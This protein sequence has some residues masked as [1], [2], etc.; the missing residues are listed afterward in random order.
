[1]KKT[2]LPSIIFILVILSGYK[3]YVIFKQKN[4][5]TKLR[6]TNIQSE[7]E[8]FDD[9]DVQQNTSTELEEIK[10]G[11]ETKNNEEVEIQKIPL[12][13][14][15]IK[16]IAIPN[17]QTINIVY[18][19]KE[20]IILRQFT[21]DDP[22]NV[23]IRLEHEKDIGD[24][25]V[26][27]YG[28]QTGY[29][30]I[31]LN[32]NDLSFI[33]RSFSDYFAS[34]DNKY[35]FSLEDSMGPG[36]LYL[37]IV[38]NKIRH[39]LIDSGVS[40]VN[41]DK[42]NILEYGKFGGEKITVSLESF[43]QKLVQENRQSE[44]Q[45]SEFQKKSIMMSKSE[46]IDLLKS[47]NNENLIFYPENS[48]K[49]NE[50]FKLINSDSKPIYDHLKSFLQKI[51]LEELYNLENVAGNKKL[52][53][54]NCEKIISEYIKITNNKPGSNMCGWNLNDYSTY[55]NG[56]PLFVYIY[57][58]NNKYFYLDI[59]QEGLG[60]TNFFNVLYDIENQKVFNLSNKL[61]SINAAYFYQNNIWF[62]EFNKITG[63]FNLETNKFEDL[64][65]SFHNKSHKWW[66]KEDSD[67]DFIVESFDK[68][69][70]VNLGKIENSNIR[71]PF[72]Y[73]K[74]AIYFEVNSSNTYFAL[75]EDIS[76]EDNNNYI[77]KIRYGNLEENGLKKCKNF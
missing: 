69:K 51:N 43:D 38:N 37:E 60:V 58:I 6:Q 13:P 36:S 59:L 10:T 57:Q 25:S 3:G 31:L 21:D 66:I 30:K 54:A 5:I 46:V 75:L 42:N 12:F 44:E 53:K 72:E 9:Q 20:R 2:I 65:K 55:K 67:T 61:K 8:V 52:T 49:N 27:T 50:S 15:F 56:D 35:I 48:F 4:D 71:K 73:I 41:F 16:I 33:N 77:A 32:K 18:D 74:K 22:L 40:Y 19:D 11:V 68:T 26:I 34:N 7:K 47:V 64:S 1:M 76:Y 14:G 29:G 39:K 17:I 70:T 62:K 28:F 24:Y 45:V 23:S 63:V